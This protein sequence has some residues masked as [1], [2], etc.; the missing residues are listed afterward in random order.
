MRIFDCFLFFNELELLELRLMT[1]VPVVD[2]FVLVEADRTHTGNLKGFIFEQNKHRYQPYLNKIIYIKVED[3]PLLDRSADAW[4]I[5]NFQRSCISRG[6]TASNDED[7]VVISDVDELPNPRILEQLKGVDHPVTLRQHLFYYYVNCYSGRGWNG[8]I[9]TPVKQM[10]PPHVLR[11]LARRGVNIMRNAGWHY[12]YMGGLD[13]IKSKLENISDAYTCNDRVGTDED[14]VRK[15]TTQKDLWD[16]TRGYQLI[17]V[18]QG[19]FGPP[20]IK[21]FIAQ[22]PNYFFGPL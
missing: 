22:Y 20:T 9:V 15:M 1:L 18:T 14:I 19:I 21:Q 3:T 12:S 8:S 10:K 2:Y 16:E 13:R 7:I 6:L 17:D 5:E 4:A 11:K